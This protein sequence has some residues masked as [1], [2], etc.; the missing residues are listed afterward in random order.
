MQITTDLIKSLRDET[1]V[2]VMQCK[3]ALEEAG[4]DVE[5]AKII[6]RK[7]SSKTAS[8][9]ADR[10]LGAGTVACYSHAGGSVGTMVELLCETDFVAKNE[11]FKALAY[12]LAMHVAAMAPEYVSADQINE[13]A[14]QKAKEIFTDEV[15]DK[16]EN[17][18]EQIIAGKLSAYFSEKTLLDQTFIKN[19]EQ[20]VSGLIEEAIQKFG[21]RIEVGRI[22]RLAPVE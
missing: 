13:E 15:K 17:I 6:L 3:K 2:S 21:E 7:Q 4:G 18:K 14:K 8:K 20:K 10:N 16:P 22:A 1:G 11:D 19:P 9:K 12:N 5:K